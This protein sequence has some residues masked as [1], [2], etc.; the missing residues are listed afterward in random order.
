MVLIV[1]RLVLATIVRNFD[2][3]SPPET[4]DQSMD[5]LD[6]NVSA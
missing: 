2:I 1:L 5:I 6:A 3:I 4:N